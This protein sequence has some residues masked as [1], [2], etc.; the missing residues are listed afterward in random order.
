MRDVRSRSKYSEDC[1]RLQL[2]RTVMSSRTRSAPMGPRRSAGYEQAERSAPMGPRR[3]QH[4]AI[5]VRDVRSRSKHIEDCSR[6]EIKKTVMS[7]RT[8][9]APMGPRRSARYERAERSAPMGPRQMQH[10]AIAG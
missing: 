5:N 6:L 7:N 9:S 1:S 2:K 4:S 8:R 3:M 10:S